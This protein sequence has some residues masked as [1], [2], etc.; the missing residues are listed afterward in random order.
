MW[1]KTLIPN[2][3]LKLFKVTFVLDCFVLVLVVVL[4]LFGGG[5]GGV[6]LHICGG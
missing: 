6:P 1:F 5:G 3:G 2:S 4:W